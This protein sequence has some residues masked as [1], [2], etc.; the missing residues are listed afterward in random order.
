M[1]AVASVV[2]KQTSYDFGVTVCKTRG[3]GEKEAVF[4]TPVPVDPINFPYFDVGRS[5][6]NVRCS[7]FFPFRYFVSR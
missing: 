7:S 5:M 3:K 6:F 1:L 2:Q 4:T